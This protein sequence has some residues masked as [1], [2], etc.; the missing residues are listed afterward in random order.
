M[1]TRGESMK[2][3]LVPCADGL[4]QDD[5]EGADVH[6]DGQFLYPGT[7]RCDETGAADALGCKL[8]IPLP[9]GADDAAF[10]AAWPAV[11]AHL[12]AAAPE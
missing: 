10:A 8:N 2:D 5:G 11:I 3:P 6:E 9:P 1:P 12:T 7:G 4:E